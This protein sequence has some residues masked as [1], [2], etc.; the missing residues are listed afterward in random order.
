MQLN[1]LK[2][3][4][5][6]EDKADPFCGSGMTGIASN[7]LGMKCILGDLSPACLHISEGYNTKFNFQMI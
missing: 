2:K 1:I 4:S 5:N 7:M 6:K 3:Y